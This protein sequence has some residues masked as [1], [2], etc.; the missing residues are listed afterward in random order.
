MLFK[1]HESLNNGYIAIASTNPGKE[2]TI[3]IWQFDSQVSSIFP[4]I[5]L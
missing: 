2:S 1:I 5:A 3:E 4:S